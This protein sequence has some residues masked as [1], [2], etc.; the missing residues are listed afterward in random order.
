MCCVRGRVSVCVSMRVCGCC[1][2]GLCSVIAA[3]VGFCLRAGAFCVLC[4]VW[5]V[6]V[7]VCVS[8]VSV[9]MCLCGCVRSCIY[10]LCVLCHCVFLVFVALWVCV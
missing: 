7:C 10:G 1:V 8:G 3:V 4:V 9:C 6:C 5:F 2:V